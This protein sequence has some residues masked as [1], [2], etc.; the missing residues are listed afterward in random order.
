[1]SASDDDRLA[2]LAGDAVES[3]SAQERAELDELREMLRAP[4]TW[5]EPDAALEDRVVAAIA[6][7]ARATRPRRA[8]RADPSRPPGPPKAAGP[9]RARHPA[10]SRCARLRVTD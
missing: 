3:L 6:E 2:Y 1:M 8:E 9:P 7:E 10:R 4:A 5:V